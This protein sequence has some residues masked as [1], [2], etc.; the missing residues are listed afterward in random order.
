MHRRPS[1]KK[2]KM[3]IHIQPMAESTSSHA[4]DEINSSLSN[5]KQI[6]PKYQL[7]QFKQEFQNR[8]GNETMDFKNITNRPSVRQLSTHSMPKATK[9]NGFEHIV[10]ENVTHKK[11]RYYNQLQTAGALPMQKYPIKYKIQ[12]IYKMGETASTTQLPKTSRIKEPSL[13][14]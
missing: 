7:F 8:L 6:G 13:F 12:S 4:Q 10:S 1:K 9:Q 3:S 14:H 11:Q 2:K 5:W